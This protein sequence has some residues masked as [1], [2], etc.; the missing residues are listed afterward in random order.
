MKTDCMEA[1]TAGKVVKT[2]SFETER[3]TYAIALIRHKGEI[4]FYKYLN[5]KIVECCNLSKKKGEYVA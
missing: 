1:I 5:G 4:Y 2:Q 3:G